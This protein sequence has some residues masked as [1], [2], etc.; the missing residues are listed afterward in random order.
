MKLL[1]KEA[2]SSVKEEIEGLIGKLEGNLPVFY[3]YSDADDLSSKA[4]L[5]GIRKRL[6]MYH[7]EYVEEFVDHGDEKE[8]L[9]QFRKN[10]FGKMTVVARP[11]HLKEVDE[12]EF[13]SSIPPFNDPDMISDLNIGRLYAGDLDYLPATAAAVKCIIDYYGLDV[14]GKKALVVGRS[15]TV[16]L[17][18]FELLHRYNA[19]VTL[20]H[21]RTSSSDIQKYASMS[22]IICLAT[23]RSSLVKRE[24]LNGNQIVIDCGYSPDGG[25]LGFV[26]D[27]DEL[28][29]YTPVPGGVGVLTSYCLVRNAL[30]LHCNNI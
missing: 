18:I 26:P 3:L 17:P 13:I 15:L 27:D 19:T 14:S 5:R 6:E 7:L 20:A 23:G 4:Y 29:A 21:S 22:D 9:L 1:G 16:G 24:S 28:A 12:N 11:L 30:F 10:S 8:S 2:L 25:D